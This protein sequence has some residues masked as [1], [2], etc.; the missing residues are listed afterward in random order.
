MTLDSSIMLPLSLAQVA[1]IRQFPAPEKIEKFYRRNVVSGTFYKVVVFAD[2]SSL[3]R[4]VYSES[5]VNADAPEIWTFPVTDSSQEEGGALRAP[6]PE[7]TH[8]L[9]GPESAVFLPGTSEAQKQKITEQDFV[10]R[11]RCLTRRRN[12]WSKGLLKI[13]KKKLAEKW[14]SNSYQKIWT[15]NLNWWTQ[16]LFILVP[17]FHSL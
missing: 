7:N 2:G 8:T 1:Y 15:F 4:S 6:Q 10:N 13:K 9:N 14:S 11:R 3:H 16:Y 17:N 5:I 12:R